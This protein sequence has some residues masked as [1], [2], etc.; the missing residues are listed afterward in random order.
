M[1]VR[2]NK[3]VSAVFA[4]LALSAVLA[5]FIVPPLVEEKRDDE[6]IVYNW[7]DYIDL[8]VL[9]DFEEYYKQLT[10][11]TVKVTYTNFD[12][13]ETMLT[14]II[15][16]DGNI[17]LICPSEYAIEKLLKADA[18]KK[19]DWSILK[20][21]GAESYVGNINKAILKKTGE[22]FGNIDSA[23]GKRSMNDYFLPYM[24]GTLGVLY[25]TDII[26]KEQIKE[27]GWGIFWNE[28][29]IPETEKK[30]L[31]KDSI[32]DTYVAGVMYLREQ[33]RLSEKYRDMSVEDLI[34]C[35]DAD[36]VEAAEEALSKQKP[37]LKGYEVD[38]GKDD[39]VKGYAYVDLAWSGDA[40]Y[41]IEEAVG[42]DGNS[43][44]DYYVPESGSNIWFDGWVIP[45]KAENTDAACLFMNYLCRP[46]VA[47]LNTLE[48]G[49]SSAVDNEK[50]LEDNEYAKAA[51]DALSD[52]YEV[53]DADAE[54]FLDP[55]GEFFGD[56]R[57]YPDITDNLGMMR[58][59]GPRNDYM[60]GM[61]ERVKA[62]G[63]TGNWG[64]LGI[65]TGILAAGIG[66]AA[67]LAV[68]KFKRAPR[69]RKVSSEDK[70]PQT[71][72]PGTR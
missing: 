3:I 68:W 70:I 22:V 44:L 24:W 33:N 12:T 2:K 54:A 26:S 31:V 16:G 42:D 71:P 7:A 10:G 55:E 23:G 25:N 11:R 45:K 21:Y 53:E 20:N 43:Y 48:I 35:T 1:N 59:F 67:G 47:M 57:R 62:R 18:L 40:M 37:R 63:E 49:Y 4:V 39:M 60:V 34:N 61:W 50:F 19:P 51:R 27:A 58:D 13:N 69:P 29:N 36:L 30:I 9:D 64:L 72:A 5:V 14:E 56:K 65:A 8:S 52:A 38:F 41:A 66:L 6:L 46:D 32:R 28:T 17:D 15:R